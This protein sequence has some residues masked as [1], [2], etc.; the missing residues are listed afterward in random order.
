MGEGE[1]QKTFRADKQAATRRL[2]KKMLSR[3]DGW[4]VERQKDQTNVR[5]RV[6]SHRATATK[7]EEAYRRIGY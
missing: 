3:L 7:G 4:L 6:N 1:A 5:R 2:R